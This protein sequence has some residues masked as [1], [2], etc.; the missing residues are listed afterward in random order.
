MKNKGFSTFNGK[1]NKIML[2]EHRL[3]A[4]TFDDII[5]C[6][7]SCFNQNNTYHAKVH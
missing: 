2:I 1:K 6:D 3:T 7:L 5:L 4:I